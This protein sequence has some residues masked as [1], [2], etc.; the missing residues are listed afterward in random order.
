MMPDVSGLRQIDY[1]SGRFPSV[2]GDI[3]GEVDAIFSR[4]LD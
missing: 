4:I 2:L 3:L 1:R